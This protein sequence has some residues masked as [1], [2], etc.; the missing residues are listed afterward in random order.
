MTINE[1]SK[2]CKEFFAEHDDFKGIIHILNNKENDDGDLIGFSGMKGTNSEILG[3]CLIMCD[4]AGVSMREVSLIAKNLSNN[5]R[6]M[7]ALANIN[8]D[9]HDD[10]GDD[11]NDDESHD[12]EEKKEC[13]GKCNRKE[14][15]KEDGK[16]SREGIAKMLVD[17]LLGD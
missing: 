5:P 11:E 9:S 15:S 1:F 6:A 3:M 8:S 12:A 4:K 2:V 16:P 17:M 7:A 13:C 10:D 14:D